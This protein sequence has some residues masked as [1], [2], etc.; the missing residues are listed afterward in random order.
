MHAHRFDWPAW[1]FP[2]PRTHT[3]MLLGNGVMGVM[4][5]GEGASLRLT[6]GRADFWDHRGGLAWTEAQSYANIRACLEQGDEPRLRALFEGAAPVPGTPRRPSILPIGR[7]ELDFGRGARLLRGHMRP[8]RGALEVVLQHRRREF[9]LE[10]ALDMER[11]LLAVRWPAALPAPRLRPVT[12][13][14]YVGPHLTSIGFTPPVPFEAGQGHGGWVQMRP[15]DPPLAVAWRQAPGACLV[16]T[17]YGADAA[18][19]RAAVAAPLRVSPARIARDTARWWR[20]Y[21]RTTPVVRL[22][23]SHL[24][25]L[26]EYGMYKFAGLTHPG[27]VAATLQGPW[28]EEYQMPPWSNDYHFNINVQMCYW[29][30]YHGNRLEHL[31]PLWRLIEGWL[32]A[33]RRNARL[34]AGV[35][36]GVMLPHAV[37]DRAT[38]MGGFWTGAIDHGCTAW[39]AQMMY[40]YCRYGGDKA[41][42]RRTAFPF[43]RGALRVYEAMLERDGERLSLPVSVSPEYR[44]AA[45]NAWGRNASFQL[46]C[47]HR[48]I[49]D[50]TDAAAWLGLPPDPAWGEIHERLPRAA[51]LN[52]D[53]PMR[54][55]IA[56]WEGTGLEESHRHHSHL[57]GLAPFDTL[58]FDAPAWAGIIDRSLRTW[59]KR[60]PGLWSGWCIPWAAMI[61]ARVGNADAAE[62]W[63]EIW[64]R[65]FTNTGHGTL[66]DV[67][68]PGFS[69]LGGGATPRTPQ[70]GGFSG[71][72]GEIMQMDAG[73]SCVTAIQEML[74]HETRGVTVLFAGA[75]VAWSDVALQ[76]FRTGGGFVLDAERRARQVVR[77][78]VRATRAGTLRLRNPWGPDRPVRARRD[79]ATRPGILTGADISLPLKAGQTALLTPTASPSKP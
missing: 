54:A 75:P 55:E 9:T 18:A 17:A 20:A 16:A 48:L 2:L 58:S 78:R 1:T 36:D 33:L 39:V 49:E 79:G 13:W 14:D 3:G 7:I 57:A 34:F 43:M 41:F 24:Q 74:L 40:R 61:H 29:P 31:R 38:C 6:I 51:L 62:L 37:D 53:D 32:P 42:L 10:L 64:R 26:Y 67:A 63:L 66:H 4:V 60:G 11:P 52:A 59:I 77:V 71:R 12:A 76:G 30:A 27:G 23:N 5:W 72:P 56:L 68:F 25:F 22:P 35:E 15:A 70:R 69:L 19:A 44:G 65:V 21:W 46:A 28:V 8:D 73:M 50:L 45:M 47:I